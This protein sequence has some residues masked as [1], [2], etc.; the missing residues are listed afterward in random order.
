MA[1]VKRAW[2]LLSLVPFFIT[3]SCKR[4]VSGIPEMDKETMDAYWRQGKAEITSYQLTK[5]ENGRSDTGSVVMIFNIA[6]I[7]K[8][9]GNQ[10]SEPKKHPGDAIEVLKCN[11]I[12]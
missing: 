9:Y 7:S 1:K 11:I 10:L 5:S 3:A 2:L 4:S 8:K 12:T 6:Y